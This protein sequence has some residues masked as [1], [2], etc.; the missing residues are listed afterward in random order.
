MAV[1]ALTMFVACAEGGESTLSPLAQAGE[2]VYLNVC[3]ACHN[4]DPTLDG[5]LGPA[6]AGSST[7]L[8]EARVLRGT[9]PP[10]Y[11]P[12]RAGSG[13]MP[14]FAYLADQIPALA[15]Y[16]REVQGSQ[17]GVE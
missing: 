1:L 13:V 4:G 3:I 7:E 17:S 6:I 10:G 16:L 11:E 14:T 5:S 12:K 8:L 9:Y 15:A 2:R